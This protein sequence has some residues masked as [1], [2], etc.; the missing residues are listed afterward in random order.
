MTRKED[1]RKKQGK[2]G[3][4][5]ERRKGI[6]MDIEERRQQ[7][8]VWDYEL[9]VWNDLNKLVLCTFKKS[10]DHTGY[11]AFLTGMTKEANALSKDGWWSTFS[12]TTT[13]TLNDP[14]KDNDVESDDDCVWLAQIIDVQK[15]KN[16]YTNFIIEPITRLG[17]KEGIIN[18]RALAFLNMYDAFAKRY[19]GDSC[20]ATMNIEM[21]KNHVGHM[22]TIE[23][24]NEVLVKI[25]GG[26]ITISD[27]ESWLST[28]S[29]YEILERMWESDDITNRIYAER[30]YPHTAKR[31]PICK[32]RRKKIT[33]RE[34]TDEGPLRDTLCY[35]D[36]QACQMLDISHSENAF[37]EVVAS[38]IET[39][40]TAK[41][42]E[43]AKK[44]EREKE[45]RKAR[46]LARKKKGD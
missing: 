33:F 27:L 31:V 26:E 29:A 5:R 8:R 25:K 9:S 23:L 42:A 1:W 40:W 32:Y 34:Y 13:P 22:L 44:R 15:D 30:A 20:S 36:I 19:A 38:R 3:V 37:A 4:L 2:L 43:Y 41:D 17:K 28:P 21:V 10:K 6:N 24:V 39:Y 18:S 7:Q 46:R 12:Y 11:R 14:T 16:N 45:A 35:W